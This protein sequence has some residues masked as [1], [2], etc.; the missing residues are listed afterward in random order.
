[1]R[2]ISR[3]AWRSVVA[4]DPSVESSIS[5]WYKVAL[6]ASWQNLVDVRKVYPHADYVQPYTIFN[7]K[8]NEYRLI[9]KIEY[10]WQIVFVKHLLTHA[11]YTRGKWKS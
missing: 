11:A 4:K 8:R 1:M 9:V 3:S 7:I 6:H 2:I 10:R 5:A